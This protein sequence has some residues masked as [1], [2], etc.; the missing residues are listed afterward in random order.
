MTIFS[1]AIIPHANF[2]IWIHHRLFLRD[3]T[4]Y[5]VL[6]LQIILQRNS[7]KWVLMHDPPNHRNPWVLSP[8]RL[9]ILR[10]V[11]HPNSRQSDD[12]L[13]QILRQGDQGLQ[14]PLRERRPWSA[15]LLSN[16]REKTLHLR[17][18]IHDQVE[19]VVWC[20]KRTPSGAC[21][22]GWSYEHLKVAWH[23]FF[24]FFFLKPHAWHWFT[25]PLLISQ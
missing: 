24:F 21:V 3:P 11:I 9:Q 7:G 19:S 5:I 23:W 18:H 25:P 15:P 6:V 8:F 14:L 2:C 22:R 12:R 13:R 20:K 1:C 4:N 16:P 17:H 10:Q